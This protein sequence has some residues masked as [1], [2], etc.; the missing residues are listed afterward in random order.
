MVLNPIGIEPTFVI[1]GGGFYSYY[2]IQCTKLD[3]ES[4]NLKKNI[5]CVQKTFNILF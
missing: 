3:K 1:A 5:L 4:K 2:N